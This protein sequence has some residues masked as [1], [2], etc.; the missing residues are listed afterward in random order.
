MARGGRRDRLSLQNK[1]QEEQRERK[2][3]S[4]KQEECPGWLTRWKITQEIAEARHSEKISQCAWFRLTI[5][6]DV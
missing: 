5:C 2:T 3:I 6:T 4:A 1:Q